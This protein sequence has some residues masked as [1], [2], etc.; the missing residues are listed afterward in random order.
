MNIKNTHLWKWLREK[1]DR[2]LLQK[3]YF[4]LKHLP[5]N[6]YENYLVANYKKMMSKWPHARDLRLDFA[7]PITFTQK[8]QWLKL[9]DQDPR[10][11]LLSDKFEVRKFIKQKIGEKYLFDLIEL[12]GKQRFFDAKEIDFSRLP[13]QFVIKCTH[14]S[15]FNIIIKDKA[16]LSKSDI[17]RIKK[18]LNT[19]LSINYAFKVGLELQYSDIIPS[20]I[21]EKYMA[22]NDDLPDYK[23]G[24]F[25]GEIKFAWVDQGRFSFHTRTFF[26]PT[27]PT[28]IIPLTLNWPRKH[29][30]SVPKNYN[31]MINVV[32][33]IADDFKFVRVDLY[34]INGV[35]YF[36][37]L[38]FSSGS[39]YECPY[40]LEYDYSFG[41]Y[42]K[43]DN[44]I[45]DNNEEY[46][47]T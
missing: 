30:L 19:W 26:D 33:K 39:G 21:I 3:E 9:Y 8:Q 12:D 22:L 47:V 28:K 46:R 13:N 36:G 18:Q 20:I 6:Q 31:E 7:N 43:I 5:R 34:N 38:T 37:E 1:K 16:K 29:N 41:E 44:A 45:R 11:T 40:P 24:C 27:D 4:Y 35:V 2:Y 17:R 10:K 32:K 42:I 14:G 23:F 25:N 15:H